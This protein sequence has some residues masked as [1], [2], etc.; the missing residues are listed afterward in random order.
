MPVRKHMQSDFP[1]PEVYN[2]FVAL[3][4]KAIMPIPEK[5]SF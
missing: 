2:R 3:Q 1:K 4:Q 5:L